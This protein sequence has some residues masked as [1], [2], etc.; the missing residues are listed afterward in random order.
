M[1][2]ILIH[3]FCHGMIPVY[4]FIS[5]CQS[6]YNNSLVVATE[7]SERIHD[8]VLFSNTTIVFH[9][10]ECALRFSSY[11]SPE[12]G[13]SNFITQFVYS[14]STLSMA[15]IISLILSGKHI[16][17]GMHYD[18]INEGMQSSKSGILTNYAS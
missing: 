3:L 6:D 15:G 9:G 17:R 11:V 12:A 18:A 16:Q 4:I 13:S 14:P 1:H 10:Y 8:C 5:S 7:R 2:I